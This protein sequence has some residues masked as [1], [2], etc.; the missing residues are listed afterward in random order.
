[1][2]HHIWNMRKSDINDNLVTFRA[3]SFQE[4]KKSLTEQKKD[5][6]FLLYLDRVLIITGKVLWVTSDADSEPAPASAGERRGRRISA[7]VFI[8]S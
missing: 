4:K 5:L 7:E 8:T 6:F 2:S 3:Q 1:M